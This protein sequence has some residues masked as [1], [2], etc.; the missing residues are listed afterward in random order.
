MS[1]A[2]GIHCI[3]QLRENSGFKTLTLEEYYHLDDLVLNNKHISCCR[4]WN[5]RFCVNPAVDAFNIWILHA[6][7]CDKS[8]YVSQDWWKWPT[9][10]FNSKPKHGIFRFT[11]SNV[12]FPFVLLI[13]SFQKRHTFKNL[14]FLTNRFKEWSCP[15]PPISVDSTIWISLSWES[16]CSTCF[17]CL[18][19][20]INIW[21]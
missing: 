20:K 18:I 4:F 11:S 6:H 15:F 2:V 8:F 16:K 21:F 14:L 10:H 9:Q 5:E 12:S 13:I 3:A 19:L 17:F 1:F 7:K